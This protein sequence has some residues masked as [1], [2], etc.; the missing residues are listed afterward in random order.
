MYR[1]TRTKEYIFGSIYLSSIPSATSQSG[2][3]RP[4]IEVSRS[5]LEVFLV[6]QPDT[7]HPNIKDIVSIQWSR[8]PPDE[9]LQ[10]A[11]VTAFFIKDGQLSDGDLV[12]SRQFD[13]MLSKKLCSPDQDDFRDDAVLSSKNW[14]L[15][16]DGLRDD[17]LSN[18]PLFKDTSDTAVLPQYLLRSVS[19]T[20]NSEPWKVRMRQFPS[21]RSWK[22][23][24]DPNIHL[25]MTT[26]LPYDRSLKMWPYDVLHLCE[27]AS[28]TSPAHDN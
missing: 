27:Q 1:D 3:I 7:R 28:S 21:I 23:L 12:E 6:E 14:S 19:G 4:P 26:A 2:L 13:A 11:S 10:T 22:Y 17:A 5:G 15:D 24:G 18:D 16:Q 25:V 8:Y 9:S 20:M